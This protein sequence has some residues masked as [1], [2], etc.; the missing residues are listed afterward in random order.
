MALIKQIQT[1]GGKTIVLVEHNMNVVMSSSDRITVM[2][3]G[4]VLAEGAPA[5]I[6]ANET[7]QSAYL[8]G[9]YEL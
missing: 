1:S 6:A 5:E 4:Q 7:V 8:G 9:L 3:Q 2:Y